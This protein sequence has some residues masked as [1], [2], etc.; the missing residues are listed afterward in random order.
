PRRFVHGDGIVVLWV[1]LTAELPLF[2]RAQLTLLGLLT[3]QLPMNGDH[4]N[5]LS[6]RIRCRYPRLR[7]LGGVG[8]GYRLD[9]VRQTGL[10]RSA[11]GHKSA[12]GPLDRLGCDRTPGI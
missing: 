10:N 8:I 1:G 6:C 5:I 12:L 7:L 2:V 3:R 11:I 4:T 9:A